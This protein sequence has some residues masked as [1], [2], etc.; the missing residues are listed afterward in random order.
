MKSF[1]D[2]NNILC[3]SQ[4]GFGHGHSTEHAILDIVNAI[5][6][7]MDKGEFSSVAFL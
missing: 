2:K 5:P 7:N 3:S 4:Y 6:S 1:I